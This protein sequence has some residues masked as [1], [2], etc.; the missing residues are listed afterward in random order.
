[1]DGW[2]DMARKGNNFGSNLRYNCLALS[3]VAMFHQLWDQ[4][5]AVR[6]SHEL[7]EVVK[8]FVEHQSH[9]LLVGLL[10][11]FLLQEPTSSLVFGQGIDL[12]NDLFQ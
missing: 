12:A 3:L 2:E 8:H 7:N 6:I 4:V 10:F 5:L 9:V 11:Q 1:M